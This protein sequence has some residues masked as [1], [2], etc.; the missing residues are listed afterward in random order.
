[1]FQSPLQT[2]SE[3]IRPV[4][5]K[6]AMSSLNFDRSS[7]FKKF[8]NFLKLETKELEKIK[9]PKISEVKPTGKRKGVFGLFGIGLFGLLAAGASGKGG[10]GDGGDDDKLFPTAGGTASQFKDVG[11]PLI[12]GLQ[13]APDPRNFR[14]RKRLSKKLFVREKRFTDILDVEEREK[15]DRARRIEERRKVVKKFPKDSRR[16]RRGRVLLRKQMIEETFAKKQ[17]EDLNK[18]YRAKF[19]QIKKIVLNNYRKKFGLEDVPNDVLE[20]MIATDKGINLNEEID[21]LTKANLKKEATKRG[22]AFIDPNSSLPS[23][24]I[25]QIKQSERF[26]ALVDEI[27]TPVDI[28]DIN[29]LE[30]ILNDPNTDPMERAEVK[31]LLSDPEVRKI[32]K[33][34]KFK[35]LAAE[36]RDGGTG[37]KFKT[38]VPEASTFFKGTRFAFKP[39]YALD[40]LFE[41]IGSVTKPFRK[42]VAENFKKLPIPKGAGSLGASILT[43]TAKGLDIINAVYQTYKLGEGLVVGDNIFTALYDLFVSIENTIQP[44]KTRLKTFITKSRDPRINAFKRLKNRKILDQIKQAEQA[45]A[46]NNNIS[47]N[48]QSSILPGTTTTPG[49][50]QFVIPFSPQ[51]SGFMFIMDKLYKQ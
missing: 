17:F 10:V 19:D 40:D 18:R 1:M 13:D 45:Q 27:N 12:R 14:G 44:D 16:N 11:L 33:E 21:K 38:V 41:G 35:N 15:A 2:V 43:N 24:V 22:V 49:G 3:K 48:N 34:T 47:P 30:D 7:D 50:G 31:K 39:K 6:S 25:E 4:S 5:S 26:K 28:D 46:G 32:K 36:G 23:N 20:D 42:I 29:K 51:Y 8:I 9:L 37:G